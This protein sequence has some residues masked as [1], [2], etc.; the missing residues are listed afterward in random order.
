MSLSYNPTPSAPLSFLARVAP[1]WGNQAT[2]G[3]EALWCRETMAGMAHGSD[4]IGNR[5]DADRVDRETVR[6]AVKHESGSVRR[7]VSRSGVI[8]PDPL[9]SRVCEALWRLPVNGRWKGRHSG[10]DGDHNM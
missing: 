5:L 9:R 3:A 10:Q 2:R 6:A 8:D 4:A 1:S 7:G